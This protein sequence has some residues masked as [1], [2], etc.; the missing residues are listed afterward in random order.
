KL[1]T[2]E[3]LRNDALDARNFFDFD[4]KNAIR[5]SQFGAKISGPISAQKSFF[6]VGYEGIRGRTEKNL[7][8]A[9]PI[10]TLCRC[11]TGPVAPLL[12]GSIRQGSELV[13][14]ASSISGCLSA[15]RRARTTS[16]GNTW[17]ARLA[18]QPFA[19]ADEV[20][21]DLKPPKSS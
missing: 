10:E 17:D 2:Y 6:F 7:Y 11:G 13:P 16:E 1:Q 21:A 4:G 15:R 3:F 12:S 20:S 9:V 18:F 5:R 19:V 14:G 8:E